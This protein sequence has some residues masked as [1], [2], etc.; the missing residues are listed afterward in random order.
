MDICDELLALMW[1]SFIIITEE[2]CD[3][4]HR[5]NPEI[6]ATSEASDRSR[7]GK[8]LKLVLVGYCTF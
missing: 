8:V 7:D 3:W 1:A 2:H 6:S 4:V 5:E